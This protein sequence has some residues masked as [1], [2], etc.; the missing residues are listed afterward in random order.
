MLALAAHRRKSC[1]M[2]PARGFQFAYWPDGWRIDCRFCDS[3]VY[4]QENSRIEV[5]CRLRPASH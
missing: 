2:L 3:D 4:Q 1:G 5:R